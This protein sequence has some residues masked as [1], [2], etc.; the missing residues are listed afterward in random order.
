M[1]KDPYE[2]PPGWKGGFRDTDPKFAYPQ[3]KPDLSSLG[4]LQSNYKNMDKITRMQGIPWPE[5][6]WLSEPN[7]NDSRV[8][9]KMA[10]DVSRIG[11]DDQGR[12]WSIVCPQIG[13]TIP[14]L[15]CVNVE[16]TVEGTRGWVDEPSYTLYADM[17]VTVQ[18]WLTKNPDAMKEPLYDLFKTVLKDDFPDSK[19]NAI[20]VPTHNKGENWNR[21]FTLVNGTAP[22]FEAPAFAEHWKDDAY[23]VSHLYATVGDPRPRKTHNGDLFAKLLVDTFSDVS[24]GFL[25]S[26]NTLSWNIWLEHPEP[27]IT[28]HW[29]T[30]AERWRTSIDVEHANPR[31]DGFPE[32][33]LVG[34]IR[35]FDGTEMSKASELVEKMQARIK[36]TVTLMKEELVTDKLRKIA[37]SIFNHF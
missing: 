6:S 23:S 22:E 26:G 16:V 3:I 34:P 21:V 1:G 19:A 31:I 13:E 18:L 8:Y 12:I 37:T 14:F 36:T 20:Q 11:Y 10:T 9:Q 24:G 4:D 28:E 27:V 7:K 29:K 35:Y 33:E 30:H 2:I 5:F 32:E 25:R 17:I 15:G